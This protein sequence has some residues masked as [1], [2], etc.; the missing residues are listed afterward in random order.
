[1]TH[2]SIGSTATTENFAN[3]EM[4]LDGRWAMPPWMPIGSVS[5]YVDE[6]A[7]GAELHAGAA[8]SSRRMCMLCDLLLCGGTRRG[9]GERES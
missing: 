9:K 2:P 8:T 6:L 7:M 5:Q 1:M 3:A 4:S